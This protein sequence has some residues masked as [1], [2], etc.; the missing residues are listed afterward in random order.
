VSLRDVMFLVWTNAISLVKRRPAVV[1]V[2]VIMA[3]D[4]ATSS[5]DSGTE[6]EFVV[7]ETG[8]VVERGTHEALLRHRGGY[9]ALW[10]P[11]S[12]GAVAA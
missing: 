8:P 7:L 10:L 5:L 3:L 12:M 9:A 2:L 1:L 11:N 4:E 6:H